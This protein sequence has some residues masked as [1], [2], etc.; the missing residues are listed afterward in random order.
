MWIDLNS[1]VTWLVALIDHTVECVCYV[2][3]MWQIWKCLTKNGHSDPCV[4][5]KEYTWKKHVEL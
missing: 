1:K 4:Q 5:P 3:N 2:R